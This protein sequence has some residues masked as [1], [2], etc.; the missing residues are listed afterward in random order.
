MLSCAIWSATK[1]VPPGLRKETRMDGVYVRALGKSRTNR[2]DGVKLGYLELRITRPSAELAGLTIE[3]CAETLC[4]QISRPFFAVMLPPA[5]I[6]PFLISM[7]PM[8]RRMC[9]GTG[10]TYKGTT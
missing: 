3:F 6:G 9:T 1:S 4:V 10:R 5:T 2:E 7:L 8:G